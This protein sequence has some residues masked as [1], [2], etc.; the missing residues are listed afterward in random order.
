MISISN[1]FFSVED[2]DAFGVDLLA[3]SEELCAEAE[4]RVH[5]VERVWSIPRDSE[6]RAAEDVI[7][8]YVAELGREGEE[9]ETEL[10][11]FLVDSDRDVHGMPL[12][13]V[14]LGGWW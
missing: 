4:A 3:C 9:L 13:L 6:S 2:G 12:R 1:R 5:A 10:T 11:G 8:D 7:V 14:F